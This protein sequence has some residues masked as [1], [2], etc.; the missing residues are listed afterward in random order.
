MLRLEDGIRNSK[1]LVDVE[2][3]HRYTIVKHSGE[4]TYWRCKNRRTCN[5]SIKTNYYLSDPLIVLKYGKPH[6]H[7]SEDAEIIVD[8][9]V[10]RIKRRAESHPNEPP[11]Q[12]IRRELANE[13]REEILVRMPERRLLLRTVNRCQNDARPGLPSTLT[14]IEIN[15]P[16][17]KTEAGVVFLQHDSGVGDANRILMF[18]TVDNLRYLCSSSAIFMDGTF[19]CAPRLFRQLYTLHAV[20]FNEVFPLIYIV[21]LNQT[22]ETYLKILRVLRNHAETLNLSFT[23]Q[24][25]HVDFE[26][27]AISAAR[28]VLPEAE[29]HGCLFHLTQS[30]F[31]YAVLNC[32]LKV[33]CA[34]FC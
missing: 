6:I 23:P 1:V 2:R 22:T 29:V 4:A 24:H 7:A 15:D 27:S 26:M 14:D 32:G 19:K 3:G 28:E 17:D 34:F 11:A 31:R 33:C 10:R 16:Y 25:I 8:A 13:N 18:Y 30:I 5:G 12:I 9:A 20:V 21:T